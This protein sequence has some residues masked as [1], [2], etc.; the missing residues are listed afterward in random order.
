MVNKLYVQIKEFIKKNYMYLLL[1]L[2]LFTTLTYPLPYYIYTGGGI[3]DV[4]GKIYVDK[5][6]KSKGSYNLCYVSE[7]I[8]TIPTYLLSY[9]IDGWDLIP[10]KEISLT[11]KET[12]EDILKRDQIDLESANQNAILTAFT[13]ANMP[14]QIT[15]THH[16]II[17][18]DEESNTNLKIGD[19]IVAIE[20]IKVNTITD[21]TDIL[22]NKKIG[23]KVSITVNSNN[24]EKEKYAVVRDEKNRKI[25]GIIFETIYDYQTVPKVEF[26]FSNSESGPSGGLMLTLAL[27]DKLVDIDI[28]KGYKISGTGTIDKDGNVGEIGGVKYKLRGAVKAKSDI[29][30]VPNGSNYEECMKLMKKYNY[31]IKII[32]VDTFDDAISKLME[33]E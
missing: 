6:T 15:D 7:I 16:Y 10:K 23:E 28:T 11:E 17:Y 26:K 29:F 32:G 13:K 9:V 1:Y 8:A 21:V 22:K 4:D 18:I 31:D 25:I 30:L 33:L 12:R 20:G 24:K 19:D 27:Y 2:V 14:Y 3:M 5:E